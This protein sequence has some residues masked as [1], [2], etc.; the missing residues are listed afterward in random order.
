MTAVAEEP[1]KEPAAPKAAR[2]P[3]PPKPAEGKEKGKGAPAAAAPAEKR[4]MVVAKV[5]SRL[6]ARYRQQIVPRLKERLGYD[7]VMAMPRLEKVVVSMGLG[8]GKEKDAKA[9][10]EEAARDLTTIT[11]QKPKVA[12]ARKA[13]AGFSLRQGQTVGLQVTLRGDRMYDFFD[14]LVSVAIPRVRDFAGLSRNGFDQG[15]SYS[16][17]LREQAVFPEIDINQVTHTQGMNIT[18]AVRSRRREDAI[19]LLEEM[20]LPLAKA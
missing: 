8:A 5:P 2:P 20:G 7:N 1:K 12:R 18:I 16:L 4:K 13:V 11:G 9:K 14:R 15:G 17:G 6:K 19:A 3:K 10:I